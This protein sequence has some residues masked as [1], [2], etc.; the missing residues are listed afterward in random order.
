MLAPPFLRLLRPGL[1]WVSVLIGSW[2][3]HAQEVGVSTNLAPEFSVIRGAFQTG[4]ADP[5]VFPQSRVRLPQPPV[6]SGTATAPEV[7]VAPDIIPDALGV[8][9]ADGFSYLWDTVECRLLGV[10]MG[11]MTDLDNREVHSVPAKRGFTAIGP[12]PLANSQDA[13]GFPLFQGYLRENGLPVFRYL[14]G[15]LAITE[16]ILPP[17]GGPDGPRFKIR[18]QIQKGSSNLLIE[19]PEALKPGIQPSAGEWDGNRLKLSPKEAVD[20]T[21]SFPL[22]PLGAAAPPQ[23]PTPAA[24]APPLPPP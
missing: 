6:V 13:F 8:T 14:W 1:T 3:S 24:P 16:T 23:A 11:P 21:L 20:F 19:I 5:L 18:Y 10:W 22:I 9:S 4:I 17:V 12:H 2:G 7:P 15:K